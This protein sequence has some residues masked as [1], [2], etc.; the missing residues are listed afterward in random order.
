MNKMANYHVT[1]NTDGSWNALRENAERASGVYRTQEDAE[2]EAKDLA[3]N[4][5]G[6]EVRVHGLD[7]K[8]RDSDTI[9]PAR[10]PFPPKDIKH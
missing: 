3:T 10:D 8:I 1:R 5:G 6:G 9:P 7:G 4:S 2:S